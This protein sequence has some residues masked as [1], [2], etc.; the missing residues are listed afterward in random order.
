MDALINEV[1]NRLT[2]IIYETKPQQFFLTLV[3]K[4]Q[5]EHMQEIMSPNQANELKKN[6][7]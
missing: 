1:P 7:T 4:I 6:L 3:L 5:H 2:E